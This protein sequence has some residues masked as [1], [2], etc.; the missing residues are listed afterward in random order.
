MWH[1]NL[2]GLINIF[3]KERKIEKIDG[4]F[5]WHKIFL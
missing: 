1:E 3:D 2:Y 4:V 5:V